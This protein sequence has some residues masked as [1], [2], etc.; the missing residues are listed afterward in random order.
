L[1][2]PDAEYG[3]VLNHFRAIVLLIIQREY[4]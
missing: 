2:N 1:E 4:V 3:S